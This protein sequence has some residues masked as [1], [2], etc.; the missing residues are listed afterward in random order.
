MGAQTIRVSVKKPKPKAKTRFGF[1]SKHGM[2]SLLAQPNNNSHLSAEADVLFKYAKPNSIQG[3][4]LMEY[5]KHPYT[6]QLYI[7]PEYIDADTFLLVLNQSDGSN[8]KFISS[9]SM[10]YFPKYGDP[11][12]IFKHDSIDFVESMRKKLRYACDGDRLLL[13]E[14]NFKA[15]DGSEETRSSAS[16]LY[17]VRRIKKMIAKN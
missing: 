11:C 6:K 13:Y 17:T 3:I 15:F 10:A 2:D 7:N 14:I 16:I 1:V 9:Y 8:N 4:W 12:F 5:L